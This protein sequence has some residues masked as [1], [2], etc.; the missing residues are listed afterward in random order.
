MDENNLARPHSSPAG[1]REGSPR[2]EQKVGYTL[3]P[4]RGWTRPF[5]PLRVTS[6]SAQR[7]AN[8]YEAFFFAL[9]GPGD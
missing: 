4:L 1:A 8:P 2:R 5:A 7:N 3:V 6:Y 9:Q